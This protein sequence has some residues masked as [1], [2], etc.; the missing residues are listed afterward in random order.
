MRMTGYIPVKSA[1]ADTNMGMIQSFS[2]EGDIYSPKEPHP[3][4]CCFP[5]GKEQVHSGQ[6]ADTLPGNQRKHQAIDSMC[7]R[8]GLL[9]VCCYREVRTHE[10]VRTEPG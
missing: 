4:L 3:K 5:R 1:Y 10:N 6:L 9:R 8:A 7:P 2:E